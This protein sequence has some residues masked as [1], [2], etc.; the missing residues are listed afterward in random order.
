MVPAFGESPFLWKSLSSLTEYTSPERTRIFVIDD[1]S[2][3][4]H[5]RVVCREFLDRVT[6][7]RNESNLGLA[8][9]FQNCINL[10]KTEYTLIMGSDDCAMEGIEDS[11]IESF[12]R[13]PDTKALQL[14]VRVINEKGSRVHGLTEL[15]KSL[16]SPVTRIDKSFSGQYLIRRILIGQFLYFP[17]IV[18][19]TQTLKEYP[20]DTRY[21]TAVDLDLILR[22][23]LNNEVFSFNTRPSFE[24]RRHGESVSS[25]L[26]QG[27]I[28]FD[29]EISVHKK[30]I[31]ESNL[32]SIYKFDVFAKLAI[33]VRLHA[34]KSGV[35]LL[36]SGTATG[37]DL[38]VR[39]LKPIRIKNRV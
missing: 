30:F 9:N 4:D 29:E 32:R 31:A 24:Y 25:K 10:S 6:Y 34:L 21:R 19:R 16:I 23:A 3:T 33:T 12:N 5:I 35:Q 7:I 13:W 15:L 1:A 39:A 17:A 11:C 26:S 27:M 14:G 37:F 2:P 8:A 38:L 22:M 28:R 20:L 18:W 36:A